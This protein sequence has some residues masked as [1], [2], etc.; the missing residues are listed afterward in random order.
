M[1]IYIHLYIYFLAIHAYAR[2]LYPHANT[3]TH[4]HTHTHTQ[5][6]L[7]YQTCAGLLQQP[8]TQTKIL[9]SQCPSIF[10]MYRNYKEDF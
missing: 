8:L 7:R 5:I 6:P 1:H 9:I 4:T 3:H 10:T 2:M